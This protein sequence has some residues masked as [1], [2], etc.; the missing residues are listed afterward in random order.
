MDL[1]YEE[2]DRLKRNGKTYQYIA[3][4]YGISRQRV[5]QILGKMDQRYFKIIPKEKVVFSGLRNW[6]NENKINIT[7]LCRRI[8]G[9]YHTVQRERLNTY[10]NGKHVMSMPM[11]LKIIDITGLTFEQLFIGDNENGNSNS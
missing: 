3:D 2:M 5:Y 11:I 6:L 1:R 10:L 4:L 8:F 9:N 7:E